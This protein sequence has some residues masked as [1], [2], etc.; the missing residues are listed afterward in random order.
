MCLWCFN[1]IREKGNG[2]CPACRQPY[3]EANFRF[4][5]PDAET[6]ARDAER[7]RERERVEMEAEKEAQRR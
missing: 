5:K 7:Q 1:N 3:T 4:S 2:Q 6:L